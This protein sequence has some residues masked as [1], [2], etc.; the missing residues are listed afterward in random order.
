MP[1]K[2]MT[3][4]FLVLMGGFAWVLCAAEPPKLSVPKSVGAVALD[5]RW[6]NFG[7][8]LKA[9]HEK[10]QEKFDRTL[11]AMQHRPPAGTEVRVK[12]RL[13]KTGAVTEI[14]QVDSNGGAQASKVCTDAVMAA[15]PF[16]KWTD[17]MIAMLGGSQEITFG[18]YFRES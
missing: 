9:M 3:L 11:Q 2:K 5:A 6:S 1:I 12:L 17:P 14:I 8:Y 4:A 7:P 15:A 18:F 16:E 10:V 13:D